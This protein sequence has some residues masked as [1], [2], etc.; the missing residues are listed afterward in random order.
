MIKFGLKYNSTSKVN[1]VA[2]R[3]KEEAADFKLKL[4][5]YCLN[6]I[7]RNVIWRWS[8]KSVPFIKLKF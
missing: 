2:T 1:L 8:Q 6:C 5:S 3:Q 7:P 4:T